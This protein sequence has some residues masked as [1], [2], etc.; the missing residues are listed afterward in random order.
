MLSYFDLVLAGIGNVVGAGIFTVIG[1]ASTYAG[2]YTWLS[3]LL[4]GLV[5]YWISKS[6]IKINHIYG[7]NNAE[8][9]AIGDAWP[10][11]KVYS[12][13][14]LVVSGLLTCY[15]VSRAFGGYTSSLASISQSTGMLLC[16]AICAALNIS[17]IGLVAS[18]NNVTTILGLL[19]LILL[20]GLGLSQAGT[21][22]PTGAVQLPGMLF[23][24]YLML[25]SY[26]GFEVLIKLS[27]DSK[28]E[29]ISR[30]IR[31]V[32][33]FTTILYTLVSYVAV[34]HGGSGQPLSAVVSHITTNPY[35][36]GYIN[37]SG[38]FMTFNTYLMSLVGTSRLIGGS[39]TNNTI[40]L[41]ICNIALYVLQLDLTKATVVNNTAVISLFAAV[42]A[43]MW[44]K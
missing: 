20:V 16:V 43:A 9:L 31:D 6:Y 18:A 17:G 22:A 15:I 40:L 38:I 2:G 3:T 33:I 29:D 14:A 8:Y 26:F 36:I 12:N 44:R 27:E 4:A 32:I 21:L 11:F 23:G 28:K 1:L 25:F 37:A 19:G 41:S 5:V 10:G 35:I 30:A 42:V 34:K 24:A 13:I 7:T 39:T